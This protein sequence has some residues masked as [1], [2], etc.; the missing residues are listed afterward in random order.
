MSW[1][2]SPHATYLPNSTPK[3][4]AAVLNDFEASHN[5]LSFHAYLQR[6]Q[7]RV[8]C[9]DGAN[10][11]GYVSPMLI[12]GLLPDGEVSLRRGGVAVYHPERA[13][14]ARR[15]VAGFF[16]VIFVCDMHQRCRRLKKSRRRPR[17]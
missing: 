14:D 1:P 15:R 3:V 17:R 8:Y 10:V 2:Y 13:R 16:L 6:P 9:T 12:Q 5:A 7:M 11:V 4:T